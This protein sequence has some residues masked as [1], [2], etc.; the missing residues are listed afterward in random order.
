MDRP[1]FPKKQI[2]ICRHHTCVIYLRLILVCFF[3][4]EKAVK[5]E[6]GVNPEQTRYCKFYTKS[7]NITNAIV[8]FLE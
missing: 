8:P 3:N 6:S 5:R 2:L 1:Y 7:L 4:S